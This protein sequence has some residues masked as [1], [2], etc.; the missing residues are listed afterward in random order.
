MNI[1]IRL[2][3][4]RERRRLTN[5]KNPNQKKGKNKKELFFSTD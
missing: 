5:A 4:V 1:I 2:G 3:N